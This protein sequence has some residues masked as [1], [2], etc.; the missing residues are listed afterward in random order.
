M[1]LSKKI[2]SL[3]DQFQSIYVITP[4]PKETLYLYNFYNEQDGNKIKRSLN[5]SKF[6]IDNVNF[7]KICPPN[8]L[9]DENLYIIKRGVCKIDKKKTESFIEAIDKSGT[10]YYKIKN[11]K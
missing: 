7:E 6:F 4:E 9:D 10:L 11:K 3:K 8:N 2:Y 1:I 5:R